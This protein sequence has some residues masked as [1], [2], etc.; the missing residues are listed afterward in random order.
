MQ[1]K[2]CSS[3]SRVQKRSSQ[4]FRQVPHKVSSSCPPALHPSWILK[5]IK[6]TRRDYICSLSSYIQYL[7]IQHYVLSQRSFEN[8]QEK[9]HKKSRFYSDTQAWLRLQDQEQVKV[10]GEA[11]SQCEQRFQAQEV[12]PQGMFWNGVVWWCRRCC[13][14]TFGFLSSTNCVLCRSSSRTGSRPESN[15]SKPVRFYSQKNQVLA[16]ITPCWSRSKTRLCQGLG[17]G[18]TRPRK[19]S[20]QKEMT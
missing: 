18:P 16:R 20:W 5:S 15:P 6:S 17:V 2:I 8:V 9:K 13:P 3:V 11:E 12:R 10:V 1:K 4:G 7:I 14:T 19:T